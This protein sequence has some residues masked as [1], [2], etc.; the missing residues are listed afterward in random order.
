ME[1]IPVIRIALG[2]LLLTSATLAGAQTASCA[3]CDGGSAAP[4]S[5]MIPVPDFPAPHEPVWLAIFDPV[6]RHPDEPGLVSIWRE[7]PD[8]VWVG[9]RTIRFDAHGLAYYPSL[10]DL[11]EGTYVAAYFDQQTS[12]APGDVPKVLLRFI[13]SRAGPMNVVEYFNTALGHYF[14]TGDPAEI[15]KLDTGA[16]AGWQR[17]GESFQAFPPD[18]IPSFGQPVCRFYGLPSA[19]LDSH[20]YS[21]SQEECAA[22]KARWPDQWIPETDAAFGVLGD[23]YAFDCTHLFRLYNNRADVNHRYTTST[24]IRDQMI[25]QG[26][27]LEAAFFPPHDDPYT[28]CVP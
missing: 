14:I 13:V 8:P 23:T 5:Y 25:A 4:P 12:P 26:W 22:V 9:A 15:E 20:F 10:V 16:I 17:T 3:S 19:G 21:A 6:R 11:L 18:Q 2:L 7:A 1:R 24:A 27:I 28:M